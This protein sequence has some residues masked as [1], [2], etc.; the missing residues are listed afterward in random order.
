MNPESVKKRPDLSDWLAG[1]TALITGGSRGIGAAI[2]RALANYGVGVWINYREND[3]AA[4]EVLGQIRK[5]GGSASLIRA[6]LLD[7]NEIRAMFATVAESGSLDILIHNAALGSF[8]P[9]QNLRPN[10]WDLTLNVNARAFLLCAQE[11]ARLMGSRGGRIIGIS[12]L[13]GSRVLPEYGA[14]GIS[15]AALEAAT[16]YLAVEM[17]AAGI[18]VNAVCG[19]L[20][21]TESIRLH[22]HYRQL[23]TVAEARTP[24]GRLGQPEDLAQIAIFLCTPLSDWLCGQVIVADGGYSLLL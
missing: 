24:A 16:R 9:V 18:R 15:K 12:S 10:Q 14:I 8:K 3:G 11:A 23:V 21:D 19:G 7:V 17:A 1:K 13:G 4:N 22:P 6:N 20:V 2:A 5:A